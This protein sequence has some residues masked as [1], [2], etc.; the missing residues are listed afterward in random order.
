VSSRI[1]RV[2]TQRSTV[3]KTKT[4]TKKRKER[5]EKKRKQRFHIQCSIVHDEKLKD[6]NK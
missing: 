4:K 2:V 5:K 1:A 3:L 6:T